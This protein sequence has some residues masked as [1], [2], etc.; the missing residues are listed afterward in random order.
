[1]TQPARRQAS[2]ADQARRAVATATS[3]TPHLARRGL[4]HRLRELLQ[5]PVRAGRRQ[6]FQRISEIQRMVSP[7]V[8]RRSPQ[9]YA[10]YISS[11][12]LLIVASGC[13]R[14]SGGGARTGRTRLHSWGTQHNPGLGRVVPT[15]RR[16]GTGR[17]QHAVALPPAPPGRTARLPPGQQGLQHAPLVIG[18]VVPPGSRQDRHE[19]SNMNMSSWSLTRIPKA[20][21][22]HRTNP[23]TDTSRSI[24]TAASDTT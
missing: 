21:L 16:H 17:T 5:Q 10:R 8:R 15:R 11:L 4:Q 20:S 22:R 3:A 9:V 24:R 12:T 13:S 14:A 2:H 6:V 18:Q 23:R 19:A 7:I 1:M